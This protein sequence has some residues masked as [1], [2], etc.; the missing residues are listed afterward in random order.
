MADVLKVL[1]DDYQSLCPDAAVVQQVLTNAGDRLINDHIALRTIDHE[2]CGIEV[3]GAPF[4]ELGYRWST[5][6]YVFKEKHLRARYLIH[7]DGLRPKV[8]IS[9]LCLDQ[10][11]LKVAAVLRPLLVEHPPDLTNPGRPWMC[12]LADYEALLSISSYAAWLLAIGWRANHFTVSVNHLSG[13]KDLEDLTSVLADA[14]ICLNQSGGLI[15]GRVEQGLRQASSM[16]PLIPV[17][18]DAG[19]Q[20]LP[21]CYVEFAQRYPLASGALYQ[22]FIPESANKIFESTDPRNV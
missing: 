21:G 2:A 3:I 19:E 13:F 17:K 16:A 8:F 12:T 9:A 11:D 22:G 6:T 14:G 7:A 15:K 1:W 4:I 20:M 18:T 5:E 10:V